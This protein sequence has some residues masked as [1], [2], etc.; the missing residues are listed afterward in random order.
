MTPS[1]SPHHEPI[2]ICTMVDKLKQAVQLRLAEGKLREGDRY[3][4][5]LFYELDDE[6]CKMFLQR[7]RG[8]RIPGT[9]YQ[10]TWNE[11]RHYFEV[12]PQTA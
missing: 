12:T 5:L 11:T 2:D 6:R 10:L 1:A 4:H 7:L 9:S 3:T 8:Y